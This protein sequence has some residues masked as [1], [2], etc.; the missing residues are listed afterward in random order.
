MAD[1]F[2]QQDFCK[3]DKQVY[4]LLLKRKYW[5]GESILRILSCDYIYY[6]DAMTLSA[7]EQQRL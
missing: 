1:R 6:D 3:D 7:D 5:P 4:V 2:Y